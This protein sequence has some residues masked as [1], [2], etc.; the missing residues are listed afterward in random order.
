MEERLGDKE[1]V[2][3]V[4]SDPREKVRATETIMCWLLRLDEVQSPNQEVRNLRRD[5]ARRLNKLLD[6]VESLG[7]VKEAASNTND[8]RSVT[9][10]DAAPGSFMLLSRRHVK[11]ADT[12]SGLSMESHV[13]SGDTAYDTASAN[14]FQ[15]LG[16]SQGASH[17]AT[18]RD[19][20]GA[21]SALSPDSSIK[22]GGF[23][24]KS[25]GN[26]TGAG[27]GGK[28]ERGAGDEE[29]RSPNP[30]RRR[31]RAWRDVLWRWRESLGGLCG[32][33]EKSR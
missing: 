32:G 21:V 12:A 4:V 24:R 3:K 5:M 23:K 6:E 1:F 26:S 16:Q 33:R 29:R 13:R 28:A 8:T 17:S 22:A 20:A 11:D 9:S 19:I 31:R 30:K 18:D 14:T 27:G 15:D 2:A 10:G 7:A 25:I